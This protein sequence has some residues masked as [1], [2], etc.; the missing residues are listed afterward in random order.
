MHVFLLLPTVAFNQKMKMVLIIVINNS[1]FSLCSHDYRNSYSGYGVFQQQ[2]QEQ[3]VHAGGD[4]CDFNS[5]RMLLFAHD[6]PVACDGYHV[7]FTR[8]DHDPCL[9]YC[10]TEPAAGGDKSGNLRTV[11][12][13]WKCEVQSSSLSKQGDKKQTMFIFTTHE[14]NNKILRLYCTRVFFNAE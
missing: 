6:V 11:L 9:L 2:V 4:V 1:F 13:V 14:S 3:Q 8:R 10:A 7:A 5:L 12:S